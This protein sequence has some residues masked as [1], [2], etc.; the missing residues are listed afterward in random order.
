[1]LAA[2]LVV[3]AVSLALNSVA[4]PLA[5]GLVEYRY[6]DSMTY[7]GIGLDA[8]ALLVVAPVAVLAAVL[9]RRRHP[10]GPVLGLAPTLFAAY[11]APQYVIGPDYLGLPGNNEDVALLH[12]ALFVLAVAAAVVAWRSCDRHLLAAL[13]GR[14][15]RTWALVGVAAFV[16]LGRQLPAVAG[17][18]ADPAS[19]AAYQDNATAFWLVLFLDLGVVTP[20]A[21]AAA[22]GLR[23]RETWAPVAAYAVVGWF[24][25]VPVSMWAMSVWVQL[26][27]DPLASAAETWLFGVAAAAL[28]GAAV[29][30][31]RPLLRGRRTTPVR[32]GHGH[33]AGRTRQP[34]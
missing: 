19:V 26:N 21:L 25:L 17:V 13:P 30:L 27:D 29:W 32:T 11:M 6:G 28:T 18:A 7:Q 9:V 23:R 34:A 24:A 14:R 4:G 3:L 12:V 10:A 31:Y 5:A 33:R 20:A 2:L 15:A 8:V 16:A 22:V 1:M